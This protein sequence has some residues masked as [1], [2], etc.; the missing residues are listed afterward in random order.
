M[1]VAENVRFGRAFAG[2][3]ADHNPQVPGEVDDLLAF[4]GLRDDAEVEA[5]AIT[6]PASG[7]SKSQWR[8]RR[9]HAF[10]CS[11]RWPPD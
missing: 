11:T 2:R 5:A 10:S 8:S 1:T 6:P 7:F 4:V 3:R 9:G